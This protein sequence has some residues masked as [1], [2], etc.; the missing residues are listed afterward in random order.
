MPLLKS[1]PQPK[2]PPSEPAPRSAWDSY[3]DA[4]KAEQPDGRDDGGD[5]GGVVVTPEREAA[6]FE[7]FAAGFKRSKKQNL[8][9]EYHGETLTVFQR[10]TDGSFGWCIADGQSSPRFSPGGFQDEDDALLS[11]WREVSGW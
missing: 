4:L 5:D 1:K 9:R 7:E 6:L 8:W 11:L 2:Q 10:P 3:Q